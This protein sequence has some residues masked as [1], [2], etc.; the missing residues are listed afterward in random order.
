MHSFLVVGNNRERVAGEVDKLVGRLKARRI[1]FGLAKIA[2]VREL[3]KLTRLGF[4]ERTAVVIEGIDQATAEAQSALLKSLE[5]P[6]RNVLYILTA[7]GE[8]GVLE[9]VS[10]RCEIV[11]AQGGRKL[12]RESRKRAEA[13]LKLSPAERLVET[14]KI[15]GRDEAEEWVESL[16]LVQREK[17]LAGEGEVSALEAML[18]ALQR[19]R[20]NGNVALQL[21]AMVINL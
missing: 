3:I 2:E 21:T 20:A 10:S 16:I 12:S 4:G 11:R 5:E 7:K 9:T 17:L 15:K 18:V 14:A 19:I 6:A 13:F 1:D 8:E